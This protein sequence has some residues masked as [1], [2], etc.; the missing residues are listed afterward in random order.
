MAHNGDTE[1]DRAL[2]ILVAEING[3]SEGQDGGPGVVLTVGGLVIGGTIIPDWQWFDEVEHAA[4]AAFTV[5]SGGSIDDESGGWARLFRGV[6]ESLVRERDEQRAA[7][8]AIGGLADRYRHLLA[9]EDRTS[10]IHLSDARVL[11]PGGGARSTTGMHWRGRLSAV[12][13]W[14][15]GHPS[16][17]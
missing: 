8:N 10:Y 16:G 4:R 13:G 9:H 14:S 7:R 12:S 17:E 11:G 3:L 15:F 2:E 5:H 1:L 6:S